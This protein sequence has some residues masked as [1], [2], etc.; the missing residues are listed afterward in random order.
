MKEE[1]KVSY[2]SYE[3]V[4]EGERRE[5]SFPNVVD[6]YNFAKRQESFYQKM[7]IEGI[8]VK[9]WYIRIKD[10][11]DFKCFIF[12]SKFNELSKYYHFDKNEVI[13]SHLE[14]A[15]NDDGYDMIL[16]GELSEIEEGSNTISTFRTSAELGHNEYAILL[17]IKNDEYLCVE[18]QVSNPSGKFSAPYE[19]GVTVEMEDCE[20]SACEYDLRDSIL[21]DNFLF[22]SYLKK[23]NK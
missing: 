19:V 22:K 3:N 2:I 13:S 16:L 23:L 11:Y 14:A 17:H 12:E 20:L 18:A 10:D 9:E 4:D 21:Y 15:N 7:Q 6:T 5:I 8:P 1:Y